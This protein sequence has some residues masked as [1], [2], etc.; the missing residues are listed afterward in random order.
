MPQHPEVTPPSSTT[1]GTSSSPFA[2]R[3]T[4]V[5]DLTYQF[6]GVGDGETEREVRGEAMKARGPLL[7]GGWAEAFTDR[8]RQRLLTARQFSSPVT[9]AVAARPEEFLSL[10]KREIAKPARRRAVGGAMALSILGRCS[11]A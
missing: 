6:G 2:S 4:V 1:T 8:T 7:S 10:G 9:V 5:G 11:L 3:S